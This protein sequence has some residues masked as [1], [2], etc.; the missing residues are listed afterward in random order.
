MI[1]ARFIAGL[2]LALALAIAAWAQ[3]PGGGGPPPTLREAVQAAYARNPQQQEIQAREAEVRALSDRAGSLI[4]DSPALE[5]G[6]RTDRVGSDDGYR[7][8]E[9]GVVLPL[10]RPG[11]RDA[12]HRLA[13]RANEGVDARRAALM[14]SVAGEVRERMWE[15]ALM[16]NNLELVQQEWETALALEHDVKRRVELGELAKTDLMLAQDATLTK[17]RAHLRAQVDLDNALQRYRAFTGLERLPR[18][19]GETPVAL[20]TLPQDHP[21]L[22]EVAARVH[23]AGAEAKLLR[24]AG[25]GAPELFVGSDNERDDSHGSY[26]NRLALSLRLPI[27]TATHTGPARAATERGRAQAQARY[28]GLRR[29]LVLAFDQ[30]A[31]EVTSA[32]QEL[33][34][35]QRQNTIVQENLRLARVAFDVGETDLVGL[36][37]V[38]RLAF[39]ALRRV[40]ELRIMRQRAIAR[41]NQAAGRLP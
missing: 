3:G 31:R 30:V 10:W 25:G 28:D 27:G 17:H 18:R 7:Q 37:R 1:A 35:A 36:L 5:G 8:W 32:Q 33:D 34:V 2:A 4:S 23:R 9:A 40:K 11:Q 39:A 14:L 29:D 19:R 15:A 41:F 21:R 24:R 6:Y 38:Q 20:D 13:A 26:N 12:A 16:K 22:L